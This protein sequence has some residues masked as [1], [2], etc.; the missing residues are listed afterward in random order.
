M[1]FETAE[2]IILYHFRQI[3]LA[4]FAYS[5]HT[6]LDVCVYVYECELRSF[7]YV[8]GSESFEKKITSKHLNFFVIEF[9]SSVTL[10]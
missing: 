9:F 4:D 10:T 6:S 5:R 7:S 1:S 2:R 3:H 8:A